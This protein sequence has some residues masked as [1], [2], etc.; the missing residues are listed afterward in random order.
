MVAFLMASQVLTVGCNE[1][2]RQ[3]AQRIAQELGPV[4]AAMAGV[5]AQTQGIG[6]ST[7]NPG[8]L[9]GN[10]ASFPG[11]TTNP[12]KPP[13]GPT[14]GTGVTSLF[15][16][17]LPGQDSGTRGAPTNGQ[18][19][20]RSL[21]LPEGSWTV[22]TNGHFYDCRSSCSR[23]HHGNDLHAPDGTD[24]YAVASGVIKQKKYNAGGY[25]WY[26]II[27]HDDVSSNGRKYETLYGH[28]LIADG[29]EIG[30]RV[31]PGQKLG[32][33]TQREVRSPH[34]HFE[35]LEANGEWKGTPLNPNA[36]ANFH[37]QGEVGPTRYAGTPS[38]GTG[39]V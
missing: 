15:P 33:V 11:L 13:S 5:I 23:P 26:L 18:S 30:T 9:P 1:D 14:V 34:L 27:E 24:V 6:S 25:H 3:N 28:I 21:P 31:T 37:P 16:T 29:I 22:G 2:D 19:F 17:G 10:L 38:L 12:V 8:T 39:I 4:L 36:F 32:I 35:V 7:I 20:F